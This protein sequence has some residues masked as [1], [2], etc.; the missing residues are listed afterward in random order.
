MDRKLIIGFLLIF[1]TVSCYVEEETNYLWISSY[2]DSIEE[3]S[4]YPAVIEMGLGFHALEDIKLNLTVSGSATEGEDFVAIPRQIIIPEGYAAMQLPIKLLDD[5][6]F[7]GDE[8]LVLEF[9]LDQSSIGLVDFE[10]YTASFNIL[11]DDYK[12]T[13]EWQ[14]SGGSSDPVSMDF[15]LHR[16]YNEDIFYVADYSPWGE[17]HFGGGFADGYYGVAAF[18]KDTGGYQGDVSYVLSVQNSTETQQFAGEFT[19]VQIDDG[20]IIIIFEKQGIN[21]EII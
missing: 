6:A 12:L 14:T 20:Q 4:D 7:E 19:N 13:L 15:Y 1:F 5:N 3:Y 11:E 10:P 16:I 2:S 8:T 17:I 18:V 21:I 9:T